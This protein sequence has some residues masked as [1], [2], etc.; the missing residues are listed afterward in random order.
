MGSTTTYRVITAETGKF[1]NSADVTDST[2]KTT[3]FV[4]N[5]DAK[6]I[7][8]FA[9]AALAYAESA[10]GQ[11]AGIQRAQPDKTST[12]DCTFAFAALPAR[13]LPRGHDHGHACLARHH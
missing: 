4:T 8:D 5:A 6:V 2:Y 13:L 11:T 7:Q 1:K 9:Q 3:D 12:G 10:A